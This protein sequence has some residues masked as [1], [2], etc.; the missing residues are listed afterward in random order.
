[1]FLQNSNF[2][3]LLVRILSGP[4]FLTVEQHSAQPAD[5]QRASP[6]DPRP[7]IESPRPQQDPNTTGAA[8]QLGPTLERVLMEQISA[9][10]SAIRRLA[11]ELKLGAIRVRRGLEASAHNR[12]IGL[13][14]STFPL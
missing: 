4:P 2:C 5:V 14:I 8:E 1:M 9:N 11:P 7:A 12:R 10:I 6:P 13:L 3:V